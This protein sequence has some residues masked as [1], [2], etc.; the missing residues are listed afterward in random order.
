[1]SGNTVEE[2]F[3]PFG[4]PEFQSRVSQLQTRDSQLEP[5]DMPASVD[6]NRTMNLDE[7]AQDRAQETGV[8][9]AL[10]HTQPRVLCLP[11]WRSNNDVSRMQVRNLSLKRWYEGGIHYI[12]GVVQAP[13]PPDPATS[14]FFDGPFF[15]WFEKESNDAKARL[16]QSLNAVAAFV[17]SNGPF[18]CAYGFSQGGA[19]VALLSFP[20]IVHR[21]TGSR[22]HLWKTCILA[23]STIDAAKALAEDVF[24]IQL[25][26]TISIPSFHIIG[27]DDLLRTESEKTMQMFA[28]R[29]K[30]ASVGNIIRSTF[31]FSGGHGVCFVDLRILFGNG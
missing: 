3:S 14:E 18:E 20:E 23:C 1:M 7:I 10:D 2:C 31:Y 19:L 13:G 22:A 9:A 8:E 27:V 17:R 24:G 25:D 16:V 6:L 28:F 21:I 11:G 30:G 4:D 26:E 12:E 15:S 5:G 29:K